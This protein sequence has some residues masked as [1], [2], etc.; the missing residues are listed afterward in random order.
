M[1]I[2]DFGNAW[3][4]NTETGERVPLTAENAPKPIRYT[5]TDSAGYRKS[6]EVCDPKI[7]VVVEHVGFWRWLWWFLF[8]WRRA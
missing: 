3:V 7:R 4:E 2:Y 1:R 5:F 8:T 6:I